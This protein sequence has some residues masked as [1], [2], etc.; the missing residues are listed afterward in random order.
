MATFQAYINPLVAWLWIGGI[1][2]VIGTGI[3]IV[4]LSPVRRRKLA[5]EAAADRGS[6][7]A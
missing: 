4:P 5:R 7:N 1:V 2:L 6:E 3:A